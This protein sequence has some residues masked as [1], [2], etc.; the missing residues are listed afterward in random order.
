MHFDSFS[1][2]IRVQSEWTMMCDVRETNGSGDGG[3]ENEEASHQ[4]R[5]WVERANRRYSMCRLNI[6]CICRSGHNQ[7]PQNARV[8]SGRFAVDAVAR[9][10]I[11]KSVK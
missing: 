11:A 7:K 1:I 8:F 9:I 5:Y 4:L 3:G 10:I 6:N 2:T